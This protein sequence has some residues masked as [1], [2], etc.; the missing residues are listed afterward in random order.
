METERIKL[1]DS[2]KAKHINIKWVEKWMEEQETCR[3]GVVA[4]TEACGHTE[5]W[6]ESKRAEFRDGLV[7]SWIKMAFYGSTMEVF[8]CF[9]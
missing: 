3:G 4:E 7:N 2:S 9:K 8:K 6:L 5:S 1:H